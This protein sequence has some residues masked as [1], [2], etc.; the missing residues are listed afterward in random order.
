MLTTYE[1]RLVLS[2]IANAFSHL[3]RGSSEAK[4]L[5][6][7]VEE[8]S[9]V[10]SVGSSVIEV[11]RE[12]TTRRTSHRRGGEAPLADTIGSYARQSRAKRPERPDDSADSAHARQLFGDHVKT[13]VH[14]LSALFRS[15]QQKAP[16]CS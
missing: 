2:F 9:D 13:D 5:V 1:H 4:E 12:R 8:N 16:R 11:C 6:D 10:L 14:R 15:H 7:W 3:H